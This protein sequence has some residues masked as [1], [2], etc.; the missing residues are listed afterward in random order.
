MLIDDG[1]RLVQLMLQ[2]MSRSP[3]AETIDSEIGDLGGDLLTPEPLFTYLRYN[4]WLEPEMLE[5]LGLGRLIP[6]LDRLREMDNSETTED[7]YEIGRR[8]AERQVEAGHFPA[9][10]DPPPE[11]P[12]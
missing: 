6:K 2:Y 7:L 11:G 10:F 9:A 8:A 3:L 4:V 12:S 5:E 1:S